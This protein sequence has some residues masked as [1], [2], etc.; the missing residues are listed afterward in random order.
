MTS[1]DKP[2]KTHSQ[3]LEL[4]RER[5]MHIADEATAIQALQNI[6]Y[7]R[8]SGY[9]YI[10]RGLVKFV[11]AAGE[12][13]QIEVG[14]R[15]KP[16]TNFDRVLDLYEFDRRLRLHVLDAIDR[17]EV[18]LRARLGYALGAGHAFAHLDRAA[19][20]ETFTLYD[21]RNPIASQ[22]LWLSS[23]HVKW[24]ANVRRDEDRSK[25]E[26]VK[27]FKSKYS[28][29]LPVWVVTELLT[30]GSAATLLSGLKQPQKNTIAA[31]FGIF[32][33]HCD[34][35]GAA[36]TKWIT[37]LVYLR[38]TCAHHGRLWNHNVV[39]QL[40]RLEGTPDLAHASGTHQR[41]RIYASLAVLAYLTSQLDP[42]STWRTDTAAM[43]RSGLAG[44]G[45]SPDRIGC[46]PLWEREPI[47]SADYQPPADPL[48]T[49]H[50]EILQQFECIGT[51]DAGLKI[52]ASSNYKRRTS[53]VR[54]HRSRSELLGFPVGS[55]YRFP[56]F[57]FDTAGARIN[58]L[59]AHVNVAL[60]AK[61]TPWAAG[62][63]WCTPNHDMDNSAPVDLLRA[64]TLTRQI[65]DRALAATDALV[66]REER[67][68]KG[69]SDHAPVIAEFTE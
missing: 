42:R 41:S 49:E 16:G 36:L 12:A 34:G 11:C 52:D 13:P 44:V 47:W 2:F 5:G 55:T 18:A 67:K 10:Y 30:F 6:G 23:E 46:P 50:R 35:D 27:H 38:N 4:L 33:E 37:N 45:E 63:W 25:H 61:N 54:Y 68:G 32:D 48:P 58:P 22:S 1:Y 65:I 15:F 57:Q 53:A 9:W 7:Y 3:Q 21:N 24:L 59:V 39:D 69:A 31:G 66:D 43:I 56:V 62:S 64:G 17:I 19:L 26:F 40:G 51:A 14:D 28:M 8:L 20:D 29:P 60:G